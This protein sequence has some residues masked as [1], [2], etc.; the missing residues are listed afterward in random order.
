MIKVTQNKKNELNRELRLSIKEDDR[1][2]LI[3]K[4]GRYID[5]GM[6][7][8]DGSVSTHFHKHRFY[9]GEEFYF[10]SFL[11]VDG[12]RTDRVYIKRTTRN[13]KYTTW[14]DVEKDTNSYC[15]VSLNDIQ[16]SYERQN[17]KELSN[18]YDFSNDELNFIINVDKSMSIRLKDI[19][20]PFNFSWNHMTHTRDKKV[21]EDFKWTDT[22]IETWKKFIEEI[23]DDEFVRDYSEYVFNKMENDIRTLYRKKYNTYLEELQIT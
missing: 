8:K 23:D 4:D 5:G 1:V 13:M 6:K 15:I 21:I 22:E 18:L 20:Q 10:D 16:F 12:N 3:L 14:S 17:D 7:K 11:K 9:S 2:T 19:I